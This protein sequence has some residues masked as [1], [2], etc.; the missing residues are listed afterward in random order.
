VTASSFARSQNS[1]RWHFIAL[2]DFQERC[3]VARD[4]SGALFVRLVPIVSE[5]DREAYEKFSIQNLDWLEEA[6]EKQNLFF[7]RRKLQSESTTDTNATVEFVSDMMVANRIYKLSETFS[8]VPED[9]PGPYMPLWQESP[10]FGQH[11]VNWNL[12]E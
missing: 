4:L 9:A 12:L 6:I 3:Q 7:D 10:T 5:D 1:T 8:I 11:L 2:N